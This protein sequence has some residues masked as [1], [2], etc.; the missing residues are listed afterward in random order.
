MSPQ[1][2]FIP[3]GNPLTVTFTA[4]INPFS[5]VNE[6][7]TGVVVEP[8]MVETEGGETEMLKSGTTG[9]GG[10]C[11]EPQPVK[12][13]T[14][15]DAI[16]SVRD[17]FMPSAAVTSRTTPRLFLFIADTPPTTRSRRVCDLQK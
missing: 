15:Q 3:I 2:A 13:Y 1:A 8:T 6:T 11:D 16:P 7:V 4:P 10:D 5:T 14:T 17:F 12:K 9:G